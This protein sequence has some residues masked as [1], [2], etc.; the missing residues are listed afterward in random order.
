MGNK[1]SKSPPPP[2]YEPEECSSPFQHDYGVP[3]EI[4]EYGSFIDPPRRNDCN[5]IFWPWH[6]LLDSE[7]KS[8]H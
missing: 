8:V 4:Y 2:S 6:R 7:P 3:E 5:C 1:Q